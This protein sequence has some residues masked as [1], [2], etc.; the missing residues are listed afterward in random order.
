MKY[1]EIN[2][3]FTEAVVAKIAQG[4]TICT[5]TMAGTQGEDLELAIRKAESERNKEPARNGFRIWRKW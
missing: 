3:A 5:Q 2:K 1:A 4:Y